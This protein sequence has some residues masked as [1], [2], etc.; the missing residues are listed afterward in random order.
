MNKALIYHW[1]IFV[2]IG[3]STTP[4]INHTSS[5][6]LTRA[7]I[8]CNTNTASI[9]NQFFIDFFIDSVKNVKQ[10][11]F[12]E[13][14]GVIEIPQRN[15]EFDTNTSLR[16]RYTHIFLG[17]KLYDFFKKNTKN[18]NNNIAFIIYHSDTFEY[19]RPIKMKIDYLFNGVKKNLHQDEMELK[20]VK[21]PSTPLPT[22]P[23]SK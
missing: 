2:M 5:A 1:I 20:A 6:K 21:F 14:R 22:P 17:D 11:Y 15:I 18:I 23:N 8:H 7:E 19:V 3:C 12:V 4:S 10:V 13:P 16:I 9:G